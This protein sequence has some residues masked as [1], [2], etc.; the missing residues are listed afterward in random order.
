MKPG[1][2]WI[3]RSS[4]GRP[5][6][7]RKKSKRPHS[8][9]LV[10]NALAPLRNNSSLLFNPF[11][12]PQHTANAARNRLLYL[13][14][15][16]H[17]QPTCYPALTQYSSPANMPSKCSSSSSQD[18]RTYAAESN[19][20]HGI[21]KP[22]PVVYPTP[23]P[24][25]F[26][27]PPPSLMPFHSPV[28]MSNGHLQLGYAPHLPTAHHMGRYP[29]QQMHH[30][31]RIINPYLPNMESTRSPCPTCGQVRPASHHHPQ[32]F[33]ASRF[34]DERINRENRVREIHSEDESS[35]SSYNTR[36]RSR[37]RSRNRNDRKDTSRRANSRR[38]GRG[39]RTADRI[40]SYT[41]YDT[42]SVSTSSRSR[43]SSLEV[44]PVGSRS[45]GR[46][47]N[48]TTSF[49]TIRFVEQPRRPRIT[50]RIVYIED[51]ARNLHN[52]RNTNY[53]DVQY[54]PPYRYGHDLVDA[55]E[56]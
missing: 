23:H 50:R 42:D 29:A 54:Q 9:D 10:S 55:M 21:L 28:H 15:P 22:P 25:M 8:T 34:P 4:D 37:H 5:Y 39:F 52:S 19:Q 31:G 24:A 30:T 7:V 49:R 38:R 46:R 33:P 1:D 53:E 44:S 48:S 13:P 11:R 12:R 6:F 17:L 45:R 16:P 56:D 14:A 41:K 32:H 3:E 18:T 47:G 20:P 27:A 2:A 35:E 26:P 40:E 36:K 51:D 43:L